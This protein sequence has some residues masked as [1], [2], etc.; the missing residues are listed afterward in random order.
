MRGRKAD[1]RNN[2][3]TTLIAIIGLAL[4]IFGAVKLYSVYTGQDKANAKAAMDSIE[5]VFENLQEGETGTANVRGIDWWVL[6]AYPENVPNRP[7][8]CAFYNCICLCEVGRGTFGKGKDLGVPQSNVIVKACQETGICRPFSEREIGT[9]TFVSAYD[10][11]KLSTFESDFE[12]FSK[13]Y[14]DP[15]YAYDSSG[16]LKPW[17]FYFFDNS[18]GLQRD[19]GG[20]FV[21]RFLPKKTGYH[22]ENYFG[23]LIAFRANNM[24]EIKVHREDNRLILVSVEE[25]QRDDVK[26]IDESALIWGKVYI[27]I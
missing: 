10:D 1:L 24:H 5:R 26:I 20:L 16:A 3:L 4:I 27:N 12:E 23:F 19:Q 7:E 14:F 25:R 18:G 17:L 6:A 15:Y 9:Y 8:K 2:I 13:E 11:P 21:W 22:N